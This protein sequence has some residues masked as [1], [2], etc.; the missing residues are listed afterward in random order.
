MKSMK[1]LDK[2]VKST[3]LDRQGLKKVGILYQCV[4]KITLKL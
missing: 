3:L 1:L 2:L 4:T